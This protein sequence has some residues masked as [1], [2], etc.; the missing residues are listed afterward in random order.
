MTKRRSR[1]DG[2]LHWDENRQRW[3]ATVTVGYDSRGKRITRRA[4][5]RTKTEAKDKL[6]ELIREYDDGLSA[7][8]G[9]YTVGNAVIYWLEHGLSGRDPHTVDMYRIYAETHI[10]PVL[11]KRKL[12]ELTVEDVEKLLVDKSEI[13]S[14]RSLQIIFSILNRAIRKAQVQDKIRRNIVLLCEVPEGRAGRPSK[15]LTLRQAEAVLKAAEQGSPRMRAY[16]VMSLLT[17]ARTEEMRALRW[18]DI[19]LVGQPDADPPV[20]SH[21]VLVRSVR[22]GGDTKTRKSRRGVELAQRAMIA[23]RVL[24]EL[25]PCSHELM[26]ACTCLVIV[27]R[28]G[29][30]MGA[31]NVRRDFRKVMDAAG[32]VGKEWTPR[33]LRQSFVS[34]LSDERVPLEVISRLVGHRSTTVTETVY[35]KQLRPVIEGGVDAMDRIFPPLANPGP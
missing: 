8:A 13:L 15:S 32:L 6:K 20:P 5:G 23:L 31:G 24:W 18:C 27:T 7:L 26:S 16:I 35:R 33:E 1:G 34:L 11:G 10:I 14:T 30:P 12:R 28:M 17:G 3:I 19:D 29:K 25:R 22:A 4:S 9:N 21:L 2:G